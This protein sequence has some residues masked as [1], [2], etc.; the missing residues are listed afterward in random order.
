[1]NFDEL[2]N[3]IDHL[4]KTC[5]CPQCK[6]SYKNKDISVIAT[7]NIEGMMEMRCPKCQVSTMVTVVISSI[8]PEIKEQLPRTH[9]TI[10]DNDLLDVK[11]FLNS[12][13]GDF[14][15]VFTQ[16]PNKKQ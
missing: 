12:F 1:M 3:T 8:N 5:K 2:K 10:S 11:N 7:T 13:D 4:K 6:S 9:K 16:I 15:K 14:K